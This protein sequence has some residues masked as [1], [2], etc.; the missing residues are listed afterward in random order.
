MGLHP[1]HRHRLPARLRRPLDRAACS[2]RR[3]SSRTTGSSAT[4]TRILIGDEATIDGIDSPRGH[5]AVRRLNRIHHHYDIP[6][7]EYA[8]VLATTIVGPVEWIRQYGW[9]RCDPHELVAITPGD[10]AVRRADGPHR[11]CPRRTTATS[12][13]CATTRP[14]G[15]PPTRP[16]GGSPRRRSGSP[17]RSRPWPLR[18]LVRRTTIALM[19]EPLRARPRPAAPAALAGRGRARG[20]AA[21][22]PGC[23][24]WR[25]RGARRTATGPRPTRTAT[26]WPTSARRRCS[27]SSTAPARAP[28][29]QAK[30]PPHDPRRR[31]TRPS[32]RTSASPPARSSSGRS[33]PTTR[34]GSAT[35]SCRGSCGSRPGEA[36]L[37]C[38]DVPEAYGGPGI[39]DFRFN[40]V[41]SEEQTRCGRLGARASR[42]TATSSSRTSARSGPR[43]RSSAGCP[44]A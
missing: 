5:A 41:L 35:G 4:T 11:A 17:G 28:A 27:T 2:T 24:G 13:C 7:D 14:S 44:A 25:R 1:G 37:L 6:P 32:T 20:A 33:C 8:Y 15:S 31:S 42:S 16:V 22:R 30:E 29:P 40:V 38:F 3:G 19:D 21:A 39:D 10:H 34:S 12:R 36:G 23:C 26:G 9:R 18:P 43:S